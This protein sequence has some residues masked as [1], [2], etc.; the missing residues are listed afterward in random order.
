MTVFR[1]GERKGVKV[2]L[3]LGRYGIHAHLFGNIHIPMIP[4][5]VGLIVS[6]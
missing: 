5:I 6:L 3:D 4:F 1:I 2:A